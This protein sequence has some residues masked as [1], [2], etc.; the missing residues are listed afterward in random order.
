M[1][2]IFAWYPRDVLNIGNLEIMIDYCLMQTRLKPLFVNCP[3]FFFANGIYTKLPG[4][5]KQVLMKQVTL[6]I[7]EWLVEIGH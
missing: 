1:H 7:M 5:M 3:G 2:F 4:L 6:L